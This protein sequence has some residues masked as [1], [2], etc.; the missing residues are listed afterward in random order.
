MVVSVLVVY[1][2]DPLADWELRL[3][4]F[5]QHH[6]SIV[7]HIDSPRKKSKF[8]IGSTVSTECMSFLHHYKVGKS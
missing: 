7:L 2:R 3:T 5:A 6:K 4:A 1:P 8:T